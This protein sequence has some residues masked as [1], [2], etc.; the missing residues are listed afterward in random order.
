MRT[1]RCVPGL[2]GNEVWKGATE[3]RVAAVRT[4][5]GLLPVEMI[6]CHSATFPDSA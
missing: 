1:S 3:G 4:I 2:V 5:R 6:A